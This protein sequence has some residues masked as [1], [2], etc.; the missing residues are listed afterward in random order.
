MR[1]L[2]L[3][4]EPF[5]VTNTP[6]LGAPNAVL[7]SRDLAQLHRLGDPLSDSTR[8]Q[9]SISKIRR[10]DSNPDLRIADVAT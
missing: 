9:A 7:A 8:H 1:S 3:R 6:P 2:E 4:L 10:L 5:N